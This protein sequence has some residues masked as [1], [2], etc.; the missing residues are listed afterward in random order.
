VL[1]ALECEPGLCDEMISAVM[2]FY[3]SVTTRFLVGLVMLC[4][5]LYQMCEHA[6]VD[7][8]CCANAAD[9][10]LRR[11]AGSVL[12]DNMNCTTR[13]W[14]TPLGICSAT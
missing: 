3:V 10:A 12:N 8:E 11:G 5:M 4:K 13:H 9:A 2:I 7:M 6:G 14:H 1:V